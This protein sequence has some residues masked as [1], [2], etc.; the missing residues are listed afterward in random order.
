MRVDI[1]LRLDGVARKST[2]TKQTKRIDA[3]ARSKKASALTSIRAGEVYHSYPR[4]AEHKNPAI[5]RV[6]MFA[7]QVAVGAAG[8]AGTILA[9]FAWAGGSL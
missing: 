2:D 5:K 8:C 3:L 1:F 4:S 7:L 6:A 9:I